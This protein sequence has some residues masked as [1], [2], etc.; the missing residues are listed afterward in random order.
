MTPERIK[1]LEETEGWRWEKEDSWFIQLENWKVQY[2]KFGRSPSQ[3][4]KDPDEKRAGLWQS[5][6]RK[7]YKNKEFC[8]TTERIK[9]LEDTEGWEWE[10]EDHWNIQLENW[11]V[12]YYKL[13]RKPFTTAKDPDEK[14][15]GSWHSVQRKAY[16]KKEKRMT[17]ER[18]KILEET[19]GWTWE[20]DLS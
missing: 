3:T 16:K 9:V 7:K 19:E 1:I 12:Q 18:I 13:G 6:Q 8:M 11:K 20:E 17:S 15:A 2:T 5:H 14:R 4:S 10:E